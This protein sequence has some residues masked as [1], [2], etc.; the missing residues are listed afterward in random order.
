MTRLERYAPLAGVGAVVLWI[1]GAYLLEKQDRPDGN[2]TVE[3]VAWVEANDSA[4]LAGGIIFGF[5]VLL[6]LW[7]LGSLRSS[8]VDAEGGTG[9]LGSLAFGS[10]VAACLCLMAMYLGHAQA[11]FDH[12]NISDT[13]VDALVHVG[14]SFFGGVQLFLIPL[15]AATAIGSLRHAAFPSWFGWLSLVLAL[16]LAFPLLGW[17]GVYLGLPV[18]AVVASMLMYRRAESRALRG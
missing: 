9:R 5:G 4:I 10:G 1:V 3:V 7:M 12:E 16:I 6:F 14:D 13:S 15:T 2:D 11:A 17:L 8:L 18:W